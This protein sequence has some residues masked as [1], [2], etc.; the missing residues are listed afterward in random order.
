MPKLSVFACPSCGASLSVEESAAT[1]T[2]QFCGNTIIVPEELRGHA[3]APSAMPVT[4]TFGSVAG[5]P[6]LGK[7]K[8][9]MRPS[10]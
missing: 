3:A 1:T 9:L 7:M 8:R 6:D 10:R 4:P 2:C 5:L